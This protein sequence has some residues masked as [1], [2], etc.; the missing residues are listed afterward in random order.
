MMISLNKNQ[1]FHLAAQF[2]R[3]QGKLGVAQWEYQSLDQSPEK[4][5]DHL[6]IYLR[7]T[8]IT[9]DKINILKKV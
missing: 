6:P 9:K 4:N 8:S 5:Q 3:N 7:L 1:N 2:E